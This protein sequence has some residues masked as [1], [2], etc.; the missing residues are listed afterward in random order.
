VAAR[1]DEFSVFF[2]IAAA[3]NAATSENTVQT[4]EPL[5]AMPSA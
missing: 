3:A 5:S 4:F 2:A 1:H